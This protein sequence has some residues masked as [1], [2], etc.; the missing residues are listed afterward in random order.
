MSK[1]TN[2][3]NSDEES[4]LL[5]DTSEL[6]KKDIKLIK[7]LK[8]Y[9]S[10]K[11]PDFIRE[12]LLKGYSEEF[13]YRI[14][15]TKFKDGLIE[16]V[17]IKPTAIFGVRQ[18]PLIV[19]SMAILIGLGTLLYYQYQTSK[20]INQNNLI[21]NQQTPPV[22]T[23]DNKVELISQTRNGGNLKNRL[24]LTQ[25]R[26]IY[27]EKSSSNKLVTDILMGLPEKLRLSSNEKLSIL[28]NKNNSPVSILSIVI[29]KDKLTVG[30]ANDMG[31]N[32]WSETYVLPNEKSVE[33]LESLSNKIVD[34]ILYVVGIK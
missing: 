30:L 28:R 9:E 18:V 7:L 10:P 22:N 14:L 31:K 17:S 8:V 26:R 33:S 12:N 20:N 2:N 32:L 3:I 5:E 4:S 6:D 15:W 21:Y 1:N 13:R 23:V 19:V 27:I 25:T 34:D 16:L 29:N 24:E 11:A